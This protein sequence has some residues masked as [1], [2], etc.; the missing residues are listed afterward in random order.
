MKQ[1][2]S[3]GGKREGAGRPTQGKTRINLTLNQELVERARARE[4]NLS[5][6]IDRLLAQWLAN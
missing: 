1:K 4:D 6:L 2:P 5:A 3:H